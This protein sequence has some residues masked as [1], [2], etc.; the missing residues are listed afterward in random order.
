MIILLFCLD[1][2]SSSLIEISDCDTDYVRESLREY[3]YPPGPIVPS[4]KRVYV[5]KLNQILHRE[6]EQK[7]DDKPINNSS[8]IFLIVIAY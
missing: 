3:G 1:E 6:T 7:H 4:T 8:G 5:R 2:C